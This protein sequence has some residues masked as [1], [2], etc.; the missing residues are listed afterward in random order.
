MS[1]ELLADLALRE[2]ELVAAERWDDLLALQAERQ[3]LIDSLPT[4]PPRQ[5]RRALES[6]RLQ[7]RATE[8][9]VEA[10]LDRTGEALAGLRRGRRVVA[11]YGASGSL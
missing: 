4:P 8:A 2:R 10:A 3:R 6:A 1:W 11:A 5:A 9:A 7:S